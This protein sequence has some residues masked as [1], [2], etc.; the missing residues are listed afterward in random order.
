MKYQFPG[1]CTVSLHITWLIHRSV[2]PSVH[3]TFEFDFFWYSMI[4]KVV[5][6]DKFVTFSSFRKERRKDGGNKGRKRRKGRREG[7]KE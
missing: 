2:G 5:P 4:K 1:P 3:S 7:M 6:L